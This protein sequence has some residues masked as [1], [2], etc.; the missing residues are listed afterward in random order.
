MIGQGKIV[1]RFGFA[2]EATDKMTASEKYLWEQCE[3]TAQ[4]AR[5][6]PNLTLEP[7]PEQ[8]QS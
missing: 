1:V 8:A 2:P 5:Q 3:Q 6:E 4:L 7:T